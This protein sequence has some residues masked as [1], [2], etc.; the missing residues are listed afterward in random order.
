M[1]YLFHVK[2]LLLLTV[3]LTGCSSTGGYTLGLTLGYK[4]I[5]A[6]IDY[7]PPKKEPVKYPVLPL[8]QK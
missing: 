7:S 8:D 4:G 1:D 2:L 6:G 5:S 3:L